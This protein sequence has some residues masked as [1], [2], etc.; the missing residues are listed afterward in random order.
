MFD[1][2]LFDILCKKIINLLAEETDSISNCL[3]GELLGEYQKILEL[4]R[5]ELDKIR[6]IINP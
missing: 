5:T 1:F 6:K 2:S 4:E 3:A